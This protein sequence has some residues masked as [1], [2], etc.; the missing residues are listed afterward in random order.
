MSASVR[1]ELIVSSSPPVF[2][3]IPIPSITVGISPA[4]QAHTCSDREGRA[5]EQEGT[6][7]ESLFFRKIP[8]V[9]GP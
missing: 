4:S 1:V 5:A 8:T 2:Q 9:R 6:F 3:P 7:N